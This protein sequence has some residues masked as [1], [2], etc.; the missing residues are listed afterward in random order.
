MVSLSDAPNVRRCTFQ[1]R[2]LPALWAPLYA[3][4]KQGM[5]GSQLSAF[6]WKNNAFLGSGFLLGWLQ[7]TNFIPR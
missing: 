1:V 7:K 3:V 4:E 2:W 5:S 6:V